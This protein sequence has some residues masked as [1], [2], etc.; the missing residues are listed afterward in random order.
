DGKAKF[1]DGL[2]NGIDLFVENKARKMQHGADADAG[3]DI[4]RT[5][6]QVADIGVESVLEFFLKRA[7]KV[8]NG[9]PGLLE[10]QAGAQSLHP[11]MVFLVD[12]DAEGLFAVEDK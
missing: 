3:A 6:G 4:S 11:K 9:Q 8:V 1:V 10:L 5:G 2:D 12:H 7:V